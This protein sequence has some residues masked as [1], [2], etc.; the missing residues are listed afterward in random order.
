MTYDNEAPFIDYHDLAQ[1]L[2]EQYNEYMAILGL[3]DEFEADTVMEYLRTI[4]PAFVLNDMV[5]SDYGRGLLLGQIM[6]HTLMAQE[7][8][9]EEA[10]EENF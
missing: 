7:R 9:L 10:D 3:F 8:A 1:V 5:E 6:A 2:T 4:E